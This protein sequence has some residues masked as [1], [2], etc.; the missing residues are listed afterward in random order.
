M[1]WAWLRGRYSDIY[2]KNPSGIIIEFWTFGEEF[3]DFW[4][5]KRKLKVGNGETLKDI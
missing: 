5:K 1:T 4:M 2:A 3:L